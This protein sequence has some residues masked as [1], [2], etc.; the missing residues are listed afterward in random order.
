MICGMDKSIPY[1]KI[2]RFVHRKLTC[3]KS[4]DLS[5]STVDIIRQVCYTVKWDGLIIYHSF[6]YNKNVICARGGIDDILE[7]K[8]SVKT[9]QKVQILAGK[10]VGKQLYCHKRYA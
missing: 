5:Q 7:F 8:T 6:V 2:Y 10:T 4:L 9:K 1:W 3:S